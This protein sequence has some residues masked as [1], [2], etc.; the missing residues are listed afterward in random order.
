[1]PS[2][3]PDMTPEERASREKKSQERF[4]EILARPGA[5]LCIAPDLLSLLRED[6][7]GT[8]VTHT[9]LFGF[10]VVVSDLLPQGTYAAVSPYNPLRLTELSF[11]DPPP[12]E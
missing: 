10:P 12:H 8:E 4:V 7:S 1:M 6:E 2:D 3:P 9:A 5:Q 11:I